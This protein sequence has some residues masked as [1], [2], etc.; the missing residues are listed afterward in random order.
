MTWFYLSFVNEGAHRGS[1]VVEA[2]NR[3]E[4]LLVASRHDCNPG[5][6][7]MIAPIPADKVELPEVVAL[8]YLL[9]QKDALLATGK[10]G[11][12]K[13]MKPGADKSAAADFVCEE[14]NDSAIKIPRK[15]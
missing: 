2:A 5:G 8:R 10:F 15:L 7:A 4:A 1:T 12:L 11:R 9:W 13:D 3:L 6:Q 14:C